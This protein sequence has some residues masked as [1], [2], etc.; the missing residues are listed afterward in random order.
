[1]AVIMPWAPEVASG[2]AGRLPR[3]ERS[4]APRIAA[5]L[6][7]CCVM[8]LVSLIQ[9]RCDIR[10]RSGPGSSHDLLAGSDHLGSGNRPRLKAGWFDVNPPFLP[11]NV[12]YLTQGGLGT[13]RIHHGGDHVFGAFGCA[14]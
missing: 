10:R 11:Q 3:E 5:A 9:G 13:H 14:G 7:G 2:A 4:I 6:K 8:H 1:M 12:A